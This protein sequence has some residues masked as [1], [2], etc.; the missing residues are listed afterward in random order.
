MI[1]HT[2]TSQLSTEYR[3]DIW[4]HAVNNIPTQELA[5]F[6]EEAICRDN[7]LFKHVQFPKIISATI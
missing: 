6:L 5:T 7:Q 2:S 1:A 4:L 3:D